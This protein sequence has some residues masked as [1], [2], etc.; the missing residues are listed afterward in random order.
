M[1]RKA[2]RTFWSL[3]SITICSLS[4]FVFSACATAT[5]SNTLSV[6]PLT[7]SISETPGIFEARLLGGG[8]LDWARNIICSPRGCALFGYTIKSFDESTDYLILLESPQGKIVSARTYGGTHRDVMHKAAPASDGGYLLVG[9]SESLFFTALKV[10]SPSRPARPFLLRIDEGGT[11]RWAVTFDSGGVTDLLDAVQT[12]DDGHVLVGYGHSAERYVEVVAAKV[13]KDG[14]VLWAYRYS[15]GTRA[16]ALGAVAVSNGDVVIVGYTTKPDPGEAVNALAI[17]IDSKG[18]PIWARTYVSNGWL[19]PKV[20]VEDADSGFLVVGDALGTSGAEDMF[21]MKLSPN[22]EA[23]W[24]RSYQASKKNHTLSSTLGRN[25]DLLALGRLGDERRGPLDGYAILLDR[26]GNIKADVIVTGQAHTE[27]IS[28]V[29]WGEKR[30]RLIGDTQGFGAAN[31]DILSFIWA[32]QAISGQFSQKEITIKATEARIV[33]T[34]LKLQR[35]SLEVPSLET[36]TPS[37]PSP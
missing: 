33:A 22:G 32:P 11:G 30:Y 15:I 25:G 7:L 19:A 31:I 8:G 24:S 4:A 35:V 29:R 27:L 2:D 5:I 1:G 23:L 10:F 16:Y 37:I 14:Q 18:T 36:T 28:A 13:S 34:P 17:R 3:L 6:R 21:V 20:V 12:S 9:R 26:K